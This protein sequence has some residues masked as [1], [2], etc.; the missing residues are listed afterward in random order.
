MC[1]SVCCS[2]K[3]R[4]EVD[5]VIAKLCRAAMLCRRDRMGSVYFSRAS[6]TQ[7]FKYSSTQLANVINIRRY[8]RYSKIVC[9]LL[10]HCV[11]TVGEK[12]EE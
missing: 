4:R 5:Y 9:E 8:Q 2:V 11:V 7:N 1:D 3:E 12:S 10:S 6:Q